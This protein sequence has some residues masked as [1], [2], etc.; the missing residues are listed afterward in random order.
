[1]RQEAVICHLDF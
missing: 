1:M